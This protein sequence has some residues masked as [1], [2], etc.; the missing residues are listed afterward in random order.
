M[1]IGYQA[2][3]SRQGVGSVAIDWTASFSTLGTYSIAIGYAA[4]VRSS[5][6]T[7]SNNTIVIN[8]SGAAVIPAFVS[9]CFIN[10]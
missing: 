9:A 3:L 10:L 4:S 1:A 8:A 7:T 6:T 2:A 5:A